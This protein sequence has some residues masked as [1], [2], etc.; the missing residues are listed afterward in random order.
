MLLIVASQGKIKKPQLAYAFCGHLY[1]FIIRKHYDKHF[2]KRHNPQT[3]EI[4]QFILSRH[5]C[6]NAQSA[7]LLN[8]QADSLLSA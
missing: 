1:Y 4:A 5:S 2:N 6:S 7:S 8:T 3:T